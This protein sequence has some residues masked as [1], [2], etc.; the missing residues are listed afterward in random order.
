MTIA[1]DAVVIG[2]TGAFGSGST[3]LADSMVT[4]LGFVKLTISQL[5]LAEWR[6]RE[7]GLD[8]DKTSSPPRGALQDLGDARRHFH[9]KTHYWVE[10]ACRQLA[11]EDQDHPRIV[12]DGIRNPGEV[13]WLRAQF[14]NFALVAVDA[15]PDV[16][17]ERLRNKD[18][19]QGRPPEEFDRVAKR[20]MDS[21]VEYG[22]RVQAC[23]DLADYVI[24]ND[25]DRTETAARR[26]LLT[27][28]DRTLRLLLKEADVE[29]SRPT[30]DEQFMHLAHAGASRSSCIKRQ[31]GAAVVTSDLADPGVK[32]V[33]SRLAAVGHNDNPD[34]MPS[35]L[36]QWR[37]CYRD[38][39]REE[40]IT[41]LGISSCPSCGSALAGEYPP[42]CTN[43]ECDEG[44][45]VLNTIFPD[46]AM[47][48]CTAIHA[49]VRAIQS[50]SPRDLVGATLYTTTFPCFRCAL[51]IVNARI[52]R[53]VYVE[54]YPDKASQMV[55]DQHGVVS[56]RFS[57]VRSTA[58]DRFF[59]SWRARAESAASASGAYAPV[60]RRA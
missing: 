22:Q 16:R 5:I 43:G 2:L 4:E 46:R 6:S 44:V 50:C 40:K 15:P 35:C 58:Y 3:M 23:V 9:G 8:D 10:E 25:E 54:A 47:S 20:D 26:H 13:E 41:E 57:G 36:E 24:T 27:G 34:Y 48:H 51:Y 14:R 18:A 19:W 45:N 1:Q 55:L 30:D 7:E 42:T 38:V 32:T 29:D 28:I 17:W 60:V 59:G 12:L 11:E 49:E 39:Y 21:P 33:A 37:G 53:V 31:V 52:A 56:D